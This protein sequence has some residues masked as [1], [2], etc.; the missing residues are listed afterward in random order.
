MTPAERVA[1]ILHDVF[2]YP[3]AEVAG[4][5]GRTPAACRQLASTARRR[6]R[7]AQPPP[8]PPA[9]QAGIV[10][11]FKQAWEAS[12]IDALI[13]LLDP[14]ATATADTGGLVSSISLRPIEGSEQIVRAW[15]VVAQDRTHPDAPGAHG[16]R[17]A[18]PDRPAR[19]R[20]RGRVRV[21]GRRRPDQAH[22][23]HAQPRETPALDNRL[24]H[25]CTP[26]TR[27]ERYQLTPPPCPG[28]DPSGGA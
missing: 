17:P 25:V 18:R 1:F 12:D 14:A 3:F 13:T 6:I 27:A 4:I 11:A 20:H 26:R 19:R 2:G 28:G 16:Q 5:V 10:R 22:L 15:A 24:T 23:G 8:A 9:R 7:A 21:R